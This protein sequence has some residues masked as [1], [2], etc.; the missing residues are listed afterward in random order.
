M[1]AAALS[2]PAAPD[3]NAAGRPATPAPASGAAPAI[4][5]PGP[6][7][8]PTIVAPVQ[9]LPTKSGK[10]YFWSPDEL[11]VLRER[12]PYGG[13]AACLPFLPARDETTIRAKARKLGLRFY[14]PYREWP[15][16]TEQLDAA[17]RKLYA[18]GL[19]KPGA[20][21]A[22]CRTWGRP[23]QWVRYRAIQLRAIVGRTRRPWTAAEDAILAEAEG[24]GARFMQKA[25]AKAGIL[26]R[27]ET[28]I[29][30]RCRKLALSALIDRGDDYTAS[31]AAAALGL[32]GHVVLRWIK[33][34]RLKATAEPCRVGEGLVWRI[35]HKD[36][37]AFLIGHP[38]DWYP[39]RCDRSWL[40]EIL[41]GRV[42]G[43]G[44]EDAAA[45]RKA[46]RRAGSDAP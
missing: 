23:R 21:T 8:L 16:S 12:Y 1:T 24:K 17:I 44:H 28:A 39:G 14:A 7:L 9:P 31:S 3:A 5:R 41:A 18:Q 22:F 15:P 2:R 46:P 35:R 19:V 4:T 38:L 37:R 20:M 40:V 33:A 45:N 43:G 26:D 34:G 6:R 11:R 29:A 10:G 30:E 13:P 25:L 27:T 36:L 42:G 32:E